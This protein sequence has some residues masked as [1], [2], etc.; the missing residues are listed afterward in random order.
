[1]FFKNE[2]IVKLFHTM[3]DVA[4]M[5][6]GLDVH[7]YV[8][9]E[10]AGMSL[11][12]G[13]SAMIWL[14]PEYP[15]QAGSK[16][17]QEV[18]LFG[19]FAHELMHILRTDFDYEALM[20]QS[21]P[22]IERSG[23]HMMSNIIEDPAIEFFAEQHIGSFLLKCLRCTIERTWRLGPDIQ[24]GTDA[25]EQF[26]VAMV[27]FCDVGL[28]KGMFTFPEAGGV[29][30]R[31]VQVANKAI[32]EPSFQKRYQ[33]AM[34]IYDIVKPLHAK[35]QERMDA[36]RSEK[37]L[38][39]ALGKSLCG[40][41]GS[42]EPVSEDQPGSGESAFSGNRKKLA[43]RKQEAEK[44]EPDG[45]LTGSIDGEEGTQGHMGNAGWQDESS[46]SAGSTCGKEKEVGSNF[47]GQDPMGTSGIPPK[48]LL[49]ELK[50]VL[51]S[52]KQKDN[53]ERLPVPEQYLPNGERSVREE[54]QEASDMEVESPFLE[55]IKVTSME[56][57]AESQ[58]YVSYY[59]RRERLLAQI[60]SLSSQLKKIFHEDREK[61][62]YR[63]NGRVDLNR[64]YG[65]RKVTAR[66][67]NKRQEPSE[68]VN[69]SVC[70]LVDLSS[71]MKGRTEDLKDT[72]TVILEALS[73]FGIHAKVVGFSSGV[74]GV[75]SLHYHF[76]SWKNEA[77]DRKNLEAMSCSGE[78]FLGYAVR[79]A[80]GLL[81][82]RKEKHKL[83][84]VV[85]DGVPQYRLYRNRQDGLDDFL[86]AIRKTKMFSDV[87]GIG[88]FRKREAE[89]Y[90]EYFEDFLVMEDTS[91]LAYVLSSRMK[92]IVKKW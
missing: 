25:Y 29:F 2:E 21:H 10:G 20:S 59:K 34:E 72:C 60:D 15:F 42:G 27:Q 26:L 61:K 51:D 88:V 48:E 86:D 12:E 33:Y 32:E 5:Y 74:N 67:F 70:I 8:T 9:D 73:R 45:P 7:V 36:N 55:G 37:K 57:E 14:N 91:D 77:C 18:Y 90:Q 1:M 65:G 80:S 49:E 28:L 46:G 62:V 56:K 52:M 6:S 4:R 81:K 39:Q 43:G 23:R 63:T 69:M 83:F 54:L 41:N 92:S 40:K 66:I 22:V 76:G 11:R 78:T 24:S 30:D 87:V 64:A 38:M 84:I 58:D 16:E 79:Y 44:K 75:D 19:V 3:E 89:K 17:D 50:G 53:A 82:R 35:H 85:T 13:Q 68:K 31:A 71:S 47:R